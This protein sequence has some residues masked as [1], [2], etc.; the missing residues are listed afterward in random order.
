MHRSHFWISAVLC[1]LLAAGG[2]LYAL[3]SINGIY[4][5]RSP[6]KDHPPAPGVATGP[7]IPR[8]LVFVLIDGLRYD[9]AQNAEVMPNLANLRQAGASARMTSHAPSY[10]QPGYSALLTGAW[11]DGSDG[12]AVNLDY[13][14]IWSFTQDNLFSAAKRAGLLTGISGYNWFEKL[15]PQT[16]VDLSFYTPGEDRT[17]DRAV[18]DAA[19]P[20]LR[21]AQANLIL[22][23]IDQVDYAGHHEGGPQDPR[24]NEA[25]ARAD[26]LL[27]EMLA[28]MD[29][30]QDTVLV[31]SDHGHIQRG[32]H[33][34]QDADVLVEP[35]V[36][37]GAGV[38]PGIYPDVQMV[39]VAP[40]LAA[41][42][43]TN[44]PAS[45]WGRVLTEALALQD[46]RLHAVTLAYSAQQAQLNTAY[47][48]A[49]GVP[50]NA[51]SLDEV[52]AWKQSI[53]R[54]PRLALALVLILLPVGYVSRKRPRGLG[55]LAAGGLLAVAVFYFYYT[56]VE[57]RALSLSAVSGQTQILLSAALGA[58]LGLAAGV[59]LAG[60]RLRRLREPG[61]W[62]EFALSVGFFAALPALWSYILNGTGPSWTIPE[63]GSAFLGVLAAL[64]TAYSALVGLA[65]AGVMFLLKPV[66]QKSPK[67]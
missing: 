30:S 34:G 11:P 10:S 45:S 63:V 60:L 51:Q 26:G 54:R 61:F 36:L 55:W 56:L 50:Q 20:W 59:A 53:D 15:V 2:A 42:L 21:S 23:H 35:F 4:D 67:R 66:F 24:W 31:V 25:A 12:P 9:T 6:L 49:I 16:A 62:T 22:V 40:T 37:A 14:D 58:L 33:G 46:D 19:L 7:A 39:D 41:L 38:R 1:L 5:Y 64:Q 28:G 13:A 47:R 65:A 43:G 57:G 29:L 18:V 3:G 48:A 44:I 8:Q 27:G 52:R 17:A 32:G